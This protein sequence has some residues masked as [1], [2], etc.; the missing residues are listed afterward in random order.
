VESMYS[1]SRG[2]GR[3]AATGRAFSGFADSGLGC[4]AGGVGSLAELRCAR[5]CGGPECPSARLN[6]QQDETNPRLSSNLVAPTL[7]AS[8]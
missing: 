3:G 1:G 8:Q 4:G 2:G 7:Q 6:L 5:R